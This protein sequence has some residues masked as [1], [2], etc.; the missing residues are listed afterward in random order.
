MCLF[1]KHITTVARLHIADVVALQPKLHYGNANDV[2]GIFDDDDN[3][4]DDDRYD[5]A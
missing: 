5:P 2:N 4:D 3:D 1:L